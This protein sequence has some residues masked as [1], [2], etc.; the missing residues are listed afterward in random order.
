MWSSMCYGIWNGMLY[1]YGMVWYG[2]KYVVWYGMWSIIWY[3]MVWFVLWYGWYV[4][5]LML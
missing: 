2:V 5:C 1:M 3:G 4:E